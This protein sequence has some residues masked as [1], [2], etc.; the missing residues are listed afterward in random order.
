MHI[1]IEV[2][3]IQRETDGGGCALNEDR[4]TPKFN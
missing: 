3:L 4:I 2:M 1:R